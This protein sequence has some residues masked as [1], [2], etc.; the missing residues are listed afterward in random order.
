[1]VKKFDSMKT[2]LR[3]LMACLTCSYITAKGN[4]EQPISKDISK[5]CRDRIREAITSCDHRSLKNIINNCKRT[6]KTLSDWDNLF[7]S[8][9]L[10]HDDCDRK[11]IEILCN[12]GAD[13]NYLRINTMYT[14]YRDVTYVHTPLHHA[15]AQHKMHVA[16]TLVALGADVEICDH[17]GRTPAHLAIDGVIDHSNDTLVAPICNF[18]LEIK[19]THPKKSV[20]EYFKNA[21]GVS[22]RSYIDEKR[23]SLQDRLSHKRA[24]Y[25][26]I[27]YESQTLDII[28]AL[29]KKLREIGLLD[30]DLE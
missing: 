18:L 2:F 21:D 25:K 22:L 8:N 4:E 30:K 23:R 7:L 10:F 12:A 3:V 6:C 17:Y 14:C 26:H 20:M 24:Q 1:M 13:I 11:T 15:I 9:L 16:K 28:A 5:K 29:D 27:T 19:K